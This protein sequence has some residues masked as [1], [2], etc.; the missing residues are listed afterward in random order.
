[1]EKFFKNF[2]ELVCRL[3]EKDSVIVEIGPGNYIPPTISI[4]QSLES[5]LK[6]KPR[7]IAVDGAITADDAFY[8]FYQ[9]GGLEEYIKRIG[10]F[11]DYLPPNLI[12]IC[13]F[14]HDLPLNT[15]SVGYVLLFKTLSKLT[16]GAMANWDKMKNSIIERFKKL[17]ILGLDE[18]DYKKLTILA[19]SLLVLEEAARIARR[20]IIIVPESEMEVKDLIEELQL[21]CKVKKIPMEVL[22]VES[23]TWSIRSESKIKEVGHW[24]DN[25][26][27]VVIYLK[28]ENYKPL[29]REG[30]ILYLKY[31]SEVSPSMCDI[32]FFGKLCEKL[33][34]AGEA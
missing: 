27:K 28:T 26:T 29:S 13:A 31:L 32:R 19:Y 2:T 4:L 22:Y 9:I 7:Y 16:D 1:M 34:Y 20:G 21:Y 30:L 23:P 25:K 5:R 12:T 24:Q 14:A 33:L 3:F 6:I 18:D 10:I 17:G 11:F 8:D 15:K